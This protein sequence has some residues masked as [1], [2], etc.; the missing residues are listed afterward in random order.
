[1]KKIQTYTYSFSKIIIKSKSN[2]PKTSHNDPVKPQTITD[3]VISLK[4]PNP[5]STN[6]SR[7]FDRILVPKDRFNLEIR[8]KKAQIS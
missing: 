7:Y 1:M 5:L 8:Q 6:Q 4:S 3:F 2:T